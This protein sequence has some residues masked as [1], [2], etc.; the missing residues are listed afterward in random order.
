MQFIRTIIFVLVTSYN[1]FSQ[2]NLIHNASFEDVDID[3]WDSPCKIGQAECMEV[4]EDDH[5]FLWNSL[6]A[7]SQYLHCSETFCSPCAM[8]HSPDWFMSQGFH[9]YVGY[10]DK[11]TPAN[12]HGL[13][14]TINARTG[15]GYIGMFPGELIEQKFFNSVP[16]IGG[17]KYVFSMYIQIARSDFFRFNSSPPALLPLNNTIPNFGDNSVMDLNI[18][19][20]KNKIKYSQLQLSCNWNIFN[21]NML[22]DNFKD[23]AFNSI[24]QL[25][26]FKV[27]PINHPYLQWHKL[28]FEFECP[29]NHSYDYIAIEQALDANDL[30]NNAYILIDDVSLIESCEFGCYKTSGT[31]DPIII[32]PANTYNVPLQI[33]NLNNVEKLK[34]EIFTILGQSP[35][36]TMNYNYTNGINTD[37]FWNGDALNAPPVA[38]GAYTCKLTCKNDCGIYTFSQNIVNIGTSAPYAPNLPLNKIEE[39]QFKSCCL[40]D[41]NLHD[42][43]LSANTHYQVQENIYVNSNVYN[44]NINLQLEAG[45]S[46]EI[47][48]EFGT[49]AN[50][51]F[52][53]YIVD[54][55]DAHKL[56][57]PILN[58]KDFIFYE[59]STS[60]TMDVND[61]LDQNNLTLSPN[62][63]T[64]GIIDIETQLNIISV[65]VLNSF[66]QFISTF[67]NTKTIDLSNCSNGVYLLKINTAQKVIIKKIILKK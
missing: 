39:K 67:Y 58:D 61:R 11:P 45:N 9:A 51:E 8:P 35:I 22:N 48:G 14:H 4:W 24:F 32:S 19:L 34:I 25:K 13:V 64:N 46:I 49:D 44:P 42:K 12:P 37:V 6:T 31:P 40:I 41:Y 57:H 53:A 55:P 20:G 62:P 36:Y 52:S 65:E 47:N 66:S 63:T 60:K 33:T 15:S 7:C 56:S 16:I 59:D 28:T 54:C 30:A 3:Y 26:N 10:K 2:N 38:I 43:T 29:T 1:I 18:Y 21:T 5:Q 17:K 50:S 27:T 23:L